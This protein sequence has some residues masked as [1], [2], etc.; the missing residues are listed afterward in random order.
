MSSP[1][2]GA[3]PMT[4]WREERA[5]DDVD[6]C[7]VANFS[8]TS[9]P[10]LGSVPSSSKTISTGRPLMPPASLSTLSAALRGA[11]VPAAVGGADAGAVQLEAEADR[12]GALRLDEAGESRRRR[13]RRRRPGPS[14]PRAGR[15]RPLR[16]V[17]IDPSAAAARRSPVA[18][19][20]QPCAAAR[21][22]STGLFASRRPAGA[23]DRYVVPV[24]AARVF[25]PRR[26][27]E[28]REAPPGAC[29]PGYCTSGQPPSS[30]GR[31][32]SSAGMVATRS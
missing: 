20:A 7:W 9:A 18:P 11:L 25:G 4:T 29:R 8:T 32:A 13:A 2:R 1:A 5:E 22:M 30:S 27:R 21:Q 6:R 12:L 19:S 15:A 31:Q 24:P 10:R 16:S 23:P 26:W 17:V 3:E 14:A 28:G